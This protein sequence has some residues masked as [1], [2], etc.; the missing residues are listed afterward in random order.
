M[1]S[2]STQM[3]RQMQRQI[4]MFW[5][6]R[7]VTWWDRKLLQGFSSA[8]VWRDR[9]KATKQTLASS[10]DKALSLQ[11][12][13]SRRGCH[14]PLTT[15]GTKGLTCEDL[16]R[17]LSATYKRNR[18]L[19]LPV[20]WAPSQEQHRPPSAQLSQW[21][22]QRAWIQQGTEPLTY[23]FLFLSKSFALYLQ[24]TCW[25]YKKILILEYFH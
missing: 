2:Y 9:C 3:L 23:S 11:P 17:A 4:W 18:C 22:N 25:R 10:K 6:E 20:S 19:P 14:Q 8:E 5:W 16:W 12:T 7:Y 24:N 13:Y 1:F 21:G 15:R